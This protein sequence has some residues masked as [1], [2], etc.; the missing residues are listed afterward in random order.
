MK[1]TYSDLKV[2]S[3]YFCH[4]NKKTFIITNIE[5]IRN[6]HK[7]QKTRYFTIKYLDEKSHV[8]EL[9]Q[10]ALLFTTCKEIS[11]EV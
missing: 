2:N 11:N 1:D 4:N 10:S 6:H 5:E 3:L 8:I 7:K 9:H